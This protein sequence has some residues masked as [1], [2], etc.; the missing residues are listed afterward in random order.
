MLI[1][2]SY[3]KRMRTIEKR[4]INRISEYK[5]RSKFKRRFEQFIIDHENNNINKSIV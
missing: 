1:N 3:Q 2:E 5:E 4:F